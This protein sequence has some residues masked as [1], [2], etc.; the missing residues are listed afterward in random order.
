MYKMQHRGTVLLQ[1]KPYKLDLGKSTL[2]HIGIKDSVKPN[3]QGVSL[4]FY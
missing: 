2:I 3:L 1:N 4:I